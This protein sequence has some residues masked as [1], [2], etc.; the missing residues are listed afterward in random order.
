MFTSDEASFFVTKEKKRAK[1][2]ARISAQAM[3]HLFKVCCLIKTLV[4]PSGGR[5]ITGKQRGFGE[6]GSP[7]EIQ[8]RQLGKKTSKDFT[9]DD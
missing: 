5:G 7:L 6:M 2:V 3:D 1:T 4:Y 9:H 8:H